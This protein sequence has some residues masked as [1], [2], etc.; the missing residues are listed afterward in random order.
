MILPKFMNVPLSEKIHSETLNKKKK[1]GNLFIVF[2]CLKIK[3]KN[4]GRLQV[5]LN[6][7]RITLDQF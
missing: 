3:K 1:N 4:S 7:S 5:A 2:V 6:R